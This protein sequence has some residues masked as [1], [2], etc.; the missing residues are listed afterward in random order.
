MKITQGH[1]VRL[2]T[3]YAQILALVAILG[4]DFGPIFASVVFGINTIANPTT[5]IFMAITC[6]LLDAGIE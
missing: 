5:N 3:T 6:S 4:V 1:F 2:F